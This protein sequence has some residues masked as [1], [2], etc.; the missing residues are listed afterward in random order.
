MSALEISS[1]CIGKSV[2]R[3][4]QFLL[5]IALNKFNNGPVLSYENHTHIVLHT[6]TS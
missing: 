3:K 6:P 4:H 5:L 1:V 2:A